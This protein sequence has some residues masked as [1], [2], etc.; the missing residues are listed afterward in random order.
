M[1]LSQTQHDIINDTRDLSA[2]EVDEY[3]NR[4]GIDKEKFKVEV[5][6]SKELLNALQNVPPPPSAKEKPFIAPVRLAGRAVGETVSGFYNL[7]RIFIPEVIDNKIQELEDSIGENL[8]RSVKKVG[9]DLFDPYHGDGFIEPLAADLA[10]LVLGRSWLGKGAKALKK[11]KHG[12]PYRTGPRATRRATTPVPAGKGL[13]TKRRARRARLKKVGQE[14]AAWGGALTIIH[15]PEDDL[16]T[17]LIQM[18]PDAP[19]IFN[20]LAIDPDNPEIIQY[21]QA[22]VNNVLTEAPFGAAYLGGRP[23][24]HNLARRSKMLSKSKINVQ[25]TR[26]SKVHQW[27]RRKFTSRYGVDDPILGSGLMRIYAGNRSVSEADGVAQ[28]LMRIVKEEAK[29]AGVSTKSIEDTMNTAL[30]GT[31]NR[32]EM[33]QAITSL[34][35]QGFTGTTT[36]LGRMRN[37]IDELSAELT[38]E[39]GLVTGDLKATIDA[40]KGIYLNRAYRL[41]DD[42]SF[43][44]WDKLPENVKLG[45]T[46]YLRNAGVEEDQ[47]EFVLK[48]ILRRGSENDFR[49]GMKFLSE[50]SLKSNKPFIPRNE[51]PP[52]IRSLMGEIKDPYK[53]FARTYEKLSVAK[54]ESNFLHDV[55]KYLL[56]HKLAVRGVPTPQGVQGAKYQ[57]PAGTADQGLISL[58]EVSDTRLS[59]IL[60]KAAVDKGQGVNPLEDLFVDKNY[61]E[62]LKEGIDLMSPTGPIMKQFLKAKALTQ[63]QKT[64]MSPATHF[65]NVFGNMILMVANGFNPISGSQPA[66]KVVWDRLRGLSTEEFGKQVGRYQELGVMDS[67]VR[68]Q[69]IKAIASDAFKFE[70]GTFATKMLDTTAGRVGKKIFQTYQAEDD[71]FKIMHFEKTK[72][73]MRKWMPDIPERELEELAAARTRDLMPN[74]ALVPKAVKFLRRSPVSDFAAWPA[75]VTRVTK[76]LLKYTWDDWSGG[77]VKDLRKKGYNISEE[78][79]SQL[80]K[81]ALARA[82]GLS[83][84]GMGGDILQNW[85][86]NVMGLGEEDVYNINRLS[87]RWSQDTAKV[88]LSPINEDKNGHIGVDFINLGPIDP[89]SYLKAPS[90][91]LVGHMLADK[92]MED[93]DLNKVGL[94]AFANVAG[95]FLDLSMITEAT[96]AAGIPFTAEGRQEMADDPR[97][98]VNKAYDTIAAPFLPGAWT[99]FKKQFIDYRQASRAGKELGRGAMSEFGY[100]MPEIE[101]TGVGGLSRWAGIRKQRLDI[102]AGMRRELLPIVTNINN[103]AGRFT[104]A[105]SDPR[106]VSKKDAAKAWREAQLYRLNEF[107]KLKSITNTYDHLLRDANL[108]KTGFNDRMDALWQGLTKNE[109]LEMN[110]NVL[111]YMDYARDNYFIPFFPTDAAEKASE[112][113]SGSDVPW[114]EL[115]R[116]GENLEGTKISDDE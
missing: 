13:W 6:E 103:A 20:A 64:V 53:N 3:F 99:D 26:L 63:T 116:A 61:I 35:D 74:Y 111:D 21:A 34:N 105:V 18:Y 75:E 43:T 114:E 84:A 94:A 57:L 90:R 62:F 38:K 92:P 89:F 107:Q 47:I 40:N 8:P 69:T 24:V 83:A 95:P 115:F 11:A 39:G 100:T 1:A 31:G 44:G 14:T 22:M 113:Y 16:L 29:Q 80:K 68:A 101:F 12:L 19:E 88:F 97:D 2:T 23:L 15:G 9:S 30:G 37:K 104:N 60:G 102:S 108:R 48:E 50:M 7:G 86:T 58:K 73:S 4:K 49:Q 109:G 32:D 82:A 65:R 110:S 52:E 27:A 36:Q 10:S 5:L 98:F 17:D 33:A 87:P 71:F 85:S 28:D 77:T 81:Q 59:N 25:E 78:G 93:S 91:M 70:P 45:A 67:S 76:N 66:R 46:Q 72:Q 51:I 54:A 41:F 56:D 55:S 96:L 42:P 106:G 112:F 79:A